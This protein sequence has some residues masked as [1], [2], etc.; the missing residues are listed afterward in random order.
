MTGNISCYDIYS[1]VEMPL[2]KAR[3]TKMSQSSPLL[4]R[5]ASLLAAAALLS[6]AACAKK[7]PATAA[8]TAPPETSRQAET[9][10]AA[11]PSSAPAPQEPDVLSQDLQHL[12]A[13]GYLKDA[14]FDYDRS[15]LREDARTALSK[16]ADWLKKYPSTKLLIE[17]H[18]DER[19][20]EEYNLALGDR[21]ANATKEYLAA[22]GI[23]DS[24]VQTV[25]FGKDKP[26]CTA[27]DDPCFQENRRAHFLITAK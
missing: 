8:S 26:F 2:P 16:D 4:P 11:P 25:S 3:R 20:T 13:R 9:R 17:G 14:F 27:D 18:C 12:N 22:L 1:N 5:A 19:G 15:E 6:L 23:N 7:Q 21:R 10:V 24:R